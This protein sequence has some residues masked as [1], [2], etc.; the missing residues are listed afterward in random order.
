MA[1]WNTTFLTAFLFCNSVLAAQV[2]AEPAPIKFHINTFELEGSSPLPTKQIDTLLS[3]FA[4]KEY[5]LS[6]LQTVSQTVEKAIRDAG[7]SF[8]RVTLPAQNVA[9]GSVTLKLLKFTVGE[10]EVN[11]NNNFAEQNILNSL[12]HLKAG[13]SPNSQTLA[14]QI[15]VANHHPDKDITV[16]FSQSEEVDQITSKVDVADTKP[17][18]LALLANNTGN[19]E[20]G[21]ARVTASL[22]HSNLWNKDHIANVSYT[23]S[24]NHFK[25]VSQYALSYSAPLYNL[26]GWLSA[27][28]TYSDIDSGRIGVTGGDLDVSGSGEM[29]GIHYLQYLKKRGAYEH[30]IDIGIDN[31]LFDNTADL[32]INN[33]N[34]GDI[35]PDI[36]STPLSLT[37]RGNIASES[38]IVSHHINFSTNL[39]I[40]SLND[41]EAYE[42]LAFATGQKLDENWH[43]LRYGLFAQKT[44]NEWTLRANLRGQYSNESLISGEQFG[45]GGAYSVRGYEEREVSSDKGN[46]VTLEAYTPAWNN[47][48]LV[49]FYDY[50]S[51]EN[52]DPL[53]NLRHKWNLSS[54]GVGVRWQ[55]ESS[56]QLSVDLAHTLRDGVETQS[57]QNNIHASIAMF[58]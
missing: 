56:I 47:A 15:K 2:H 35:S 45:L 20:T 14:H 19:Q 10:I 50:G 11:G 31:R 34:Q 17:L 42:D 9:D 28:Y 33:L 58:Y 8:H 22:Q 49:A 21:K 32:T 41:S 26:S 37:Y 46:I 24:P 44:V 7:Y 40:G 30:S 23:T 43:V 51:G 57:H 4:D 29:Y 55:Y 16:V 6:E 3:G 54:I 38:L 1:A 36:R 5:G 25:E 12:P 48:N 39:G 53:P 52:H 27:Y 13:E 18:R